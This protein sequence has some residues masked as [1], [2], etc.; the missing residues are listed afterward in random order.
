MLSLENHQSL[1]GSAQE[2]DQK[3]YIFSEQLWTDIDLHRNNDKSPKALPVCNCQNPFCDNH[4]TADE[5]L[6]QEWASINQKPDQK[7]KPVSIPPSPIHPKELSNA[8]QKPAA[9]SPPIPAPTTISSPPRKSTLWH[10]RRTRTKNELLLLATAP[11]PQCDEPSCPLNQSPYN[12]NHAKGPY[13]HNGQSLSLILAGHASKYLIS[14]IVDFG[15]SLPP[16]GIWQAYERM[17]KRRG[18]EGDREVVL[19]FF[20]GHCTLEAMERLLRRLE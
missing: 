7:E 9:I 4:G 1:I 15:G 5:D 16:W 3:A 19:G 2:A 13:V 12:I 8:P 11:P 14:I 18:E 20:A 10:N 6:S 17:V